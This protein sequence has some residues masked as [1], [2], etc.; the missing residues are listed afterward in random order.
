MSAS[1]KADAIVSVRGTEKALPEHTRQVNR[2]LILR[3]LFRSDPMSRAD[4]ARA[5]GLTRVSVS[6]IVDDLAAEGLVRESGPSPEGR[7]GKPSTLIALNPDSYHVVSLDL[8]AYA[9]LTGAIMNLDGAVVHSMSVPTDGAR[10]SALLQKVCALASALVKRS[11]VRV[12]GVGVGSPGVVNTEGVVREA[13]AFDWHDLDVAAAISAVVPAPVHVANDA[14]A[15]ALAARTYGQPGVDNLALVRIGQGIGS[16]VIVGGALVTGDR[17]TAGEIGH[18]LVDEGGEV[19]RCGRR[20]CL[21]V[22]AAV[23]YLRQRLADSPASADEVLTR[24]GRAL[25]RV[26]T[27]VVAALGLEQVV[28]S[29]PLDIVGGVFLEQTRAAIEH[30]ALA[31]V[32]DDFE[33]RVAVRGDDI[34]LLGG[35]ALVV[36]EELGIR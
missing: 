3:T 19:C 15:A 22:V 12:L 23:P 14:N 21:E 9:E 33:I 5:T 36:A 27:P 11:T 29:G 35:T 1:K 7:V 6:R 18:V 13:V 2:S 31:I 20:G 24:A 32:T 8:S 4:L 16:G 30:E 26:L 34:V 25:G 10:G 28:L 17:F